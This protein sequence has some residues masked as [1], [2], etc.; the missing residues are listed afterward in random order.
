MRVL[1]TGA[2]GYTGGHLSRALV[3]QGHAVRALV[4]DSER[5]KAIAADGIVP[6]VGDLRDAAAV[7]TAVD[8]VEVIY[9]VAAVYREAGIADEVYRAVNTTAVGDLVTAAAAAG[10][11][12]VVH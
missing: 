5:A 6:T 7:R 3:G 8:G 12:R 10:V 9:H 1:V 2:S 4:R 11:R